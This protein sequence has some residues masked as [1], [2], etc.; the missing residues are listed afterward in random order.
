[1]IIIII[2]MIDDNDAIMTKRPFSQS[3]LRF[4]LIRFN[5]TVICA[6]RAKM[7]K[8]SRRKAAFTFEI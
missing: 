4:F 5:E 6:K 7:E 1:M 2:R 3:I 8:E